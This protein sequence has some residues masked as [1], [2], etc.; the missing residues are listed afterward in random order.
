MSGGTNISKER[1]LALSHEHV[2]V[3]P[4][5]PAWPKRYQEEEDLLVRSLPPDL[6]QRIVHIGSTAVPGL[7]AKPIIDLQVEVNSLDRVRREVVPIMQ[8][9]GHEYIWRP[10]MGESAPFYAWFIRRDAAGKR[11][12]HVH[13]VEPDA[14]SE[15]R[16]LFRDHLR[17]HAELAAKYE[18]LKRDLAAHFPDDRTAY[19][20]GK[21]EFILDVVRRAR[22][23]H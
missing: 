6:V 13:M 9:L 11:T 2:D 3:Q 12:H 16:V 22:A 7:S 10:T 5:D 14:A 17:A 23:G 18:T 1:I 21:T 8:D 15:D 4:Y 19:T 20:K